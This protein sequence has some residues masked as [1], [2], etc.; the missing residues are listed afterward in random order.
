MPGILRSRSPTR[1][2]GR[3]HRDRNDHRDNEYAA[4]HLQDEDARAH[5][6]RSGQRLQYILIGNGPDP[7][8][9]QSGN[10]ESPQ[11]AIESRR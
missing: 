8:Q 2:D 7:G 4:D 5:G 3:D 10:P 9:G 6:A 1:G 11:Y